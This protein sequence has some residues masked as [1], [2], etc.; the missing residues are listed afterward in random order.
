MHLPRALCT[1]AV[2]RLSALEPISYP[3]SS[4]EAAWIAEADLVCD[5]DDVDVHGDG[6][7]DDDDH[8]AVDDEARRGVDDD[9]D[10]D[11]ED[12]DVDDEARWD[13]SQA[14]RALIKLQSLLD[15][16][17]RVFIRNSRDR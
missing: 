4:V 14:D 2:S 11:D 16:S 8:D 10:V 9:D 6:V 17:L 1:A 3:E 5:D 7:Y 15:G 13:V 12:V